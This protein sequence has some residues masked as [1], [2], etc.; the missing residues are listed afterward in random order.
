MEFGRPVEHIRV[1]PGMTVGSLLA[2]MDEAGVLG[3]G[4]LGRAARILA[5]MFS[6]PDCSVFLSL[7]GALV[8]G[9]L[10]SVIRDLVERGLL[11]AIVTTGANV[12]H[13]L[14][15]ALGFRHY[16]GTFRAD[17][18]ELL[19]EKLGRIGD[20]YVEMR[21]FV[22]LEKWLRDVLKEVPADVRKAISG[23]R[24]IRELGLRLEDPNSIV[25]TAARKGV[26]IICPGFVD[27]VAGFQL[28]TLSDELGLRLDPLGDL[29]E[30]MNLV[31]T[32][33][34]VGLVILGGG[35]PK[36]FLMFATTFRDGADYAIQITTDRPEPGGLSGAPLEEAISWGKIKP[37]ADVV[38]VIC[39]ATIAFPL[40]VAAALEW[41]C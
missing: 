12:V 24:L 22:A 27:C 10:R 2:Q 31:L 19:E 17:D 6:D 3:A 14:V 33:E 37:G 5:K 28:W 34:R 38:T 18:A 20:I 16:V 39:D 40:I 21:A 25:A 4:K 11:K 8:P 1:R 41:A 35:M 9:G 15:E 7:A 36:H 13:D 23:S 30:L 32:A 26:P 29:S